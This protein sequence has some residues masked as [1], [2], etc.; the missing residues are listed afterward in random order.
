MAV[1]FLGMPH[2]RPISGGGHASV[3]RGG[4]ARTPST[5]PRELLG[6]GPRP[7]V[8]GVD[9]D[10]RQVAAAGL[11]PGHRRAARPRSRGARPPAPDGDRRTPG[12]WLAQAGDDVG[13]VEVDAVLGVFC[14]TSGP[15]AA[16]RGRVEGAPTGARTATGGGPTPISGSQGTWKSQT[17]QLCSTWG[18]SRSR[19]LHVDARLPRWSRDGPLAGGVR[20]DPALEPRVP[21]LG[22]EHVPAGDRAPVVRDQVHAFARSG[23]SRRA[24]RSGPRRAARCGTTTAR[25]ACVDRP[26]PRTS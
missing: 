14:R 24:R 10:V 5:S 11:E 18:S 15:T 23:G 6:T 22:G 16:A 7:P 19:P 20:R 3:L 17:Y 8:T 1:R 9:L 26:E 21:G 4:R 2:Q 13:A 12:Q 25:S